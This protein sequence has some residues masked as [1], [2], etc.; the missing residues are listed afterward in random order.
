[1]IYE[2]YSCKSVTE[3]FI[4]KFKLLLTIIEIK[5]VANVIETI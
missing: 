1:M 5:I 2:I 3:S 4:D